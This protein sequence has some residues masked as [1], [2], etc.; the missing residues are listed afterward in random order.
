MP[1]ATGK[2]DAEFDLTGSELPDWIVAGMSCKV[3]VTTYDKD[4][5]LVVPKKAVHTDKDDEELK[6]VWL[7]DVKDDDAKD[8]DAKA[9]AS[10][11]E[12]RQDRAA[13]TSKSLERPQGGRRRFARRRREE[14]RR[15][16]E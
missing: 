6:Y 7:V 16:E 3:K 4:D 11:R 9:G 15:R 8:A 12:A 1:V 2:F 13:R 14:G 5:A 10:R